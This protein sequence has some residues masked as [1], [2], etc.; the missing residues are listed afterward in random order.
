MELETL[1][2]VSS[3]T[4]AATSSSSS[5]AI[6]AAR[7]S[8][9]RSSTSSRSVHI[10]HGIERSS[11]LLLWL[12]RK[13]GFLCFRFYLSS[14]SCIRE[15]ERE[16]AALIRQIDR[17]WIFSR[18]FL[19]CCPIR[20]AWDVQWG[21]CETHPLHS[22]PKN[23]DALRLQK[24]GPTWC[25]IRVGHTHIPLWISYVSRV[26]IHSNGLG[27]WID[28]TLVWIGWTHGTWAQDN[29]FR[30][31]GRFFLERSAPP[32]SSKKTPAPAL[33]GA[34]NGPTNQVRTNACL[35]VCVRRVLENSRW[36]FK[37]KKK[38]SPS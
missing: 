3:I 21:T 27:H 16:T 37:K 24:C 31:I 13:T 9:V 11:V 35:Y 12:E 5:S 38:K 26:C 28:Y 20:T 1:T 36:A 18:A 32:R 6:A 4:T 19:S 14:S 22:R 8:I 30:M 10:R 29:K 17:Y 2:S 7:W 34:T 33:G 23:E 25:S 15:R